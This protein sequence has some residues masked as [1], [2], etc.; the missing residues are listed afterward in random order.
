MYF[1]SREKIV[2]IIKKHKKKKEYFWCPDL[3]SIMCI[4]GNN[5]D[6]EYYYERFF[7]E[8]KVYFDEFDIS[9]FLAKEKKDID[10]NYY[11]SLQKD[12]LIKNYDILMYNISDKIGFNSYSVYDVISLYDFFY[13]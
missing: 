10:M 11:V 7:F 5:S 12:F 8:K 13:K 4:N 1:F 9:I 6:D 3:T 2:E